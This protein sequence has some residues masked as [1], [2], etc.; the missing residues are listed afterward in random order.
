VLHCPTQAVRREKNT[1]WANKMPAQFSEKPADGFSADSQ[2]TQTRILP[3]FVTVDVKG[4]PR[5][6]ITFKL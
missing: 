6:D 1:I 5:L 2:T 3:I 4:V